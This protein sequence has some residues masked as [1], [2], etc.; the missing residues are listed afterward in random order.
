MTA[1]PIPLVL[2]VEADPVQRD[3]MQISLK[4]MG[5]DV[6]CTREPQQVSILVAKQHPSLI[7]LDTFLPGSSGMEI[8]KELS[9]KKLIRHSHVLVISS[10]GFP[11]IIQQVK[12][13]GIN[14]F[15]M[16]PLDIDDFGKRV[17]TL[18]EI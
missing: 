4:R 16:K 9:Q 3:L 1:N 7:I 11:E 18:L 10:Y 17:K 2:I 14:E 13:H 5:C 15:L 12:D 8:I 6:I